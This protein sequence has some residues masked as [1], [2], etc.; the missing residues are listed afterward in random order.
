MLAGMGGRTTVFGSDRRVLLWRLRPEER[1]GE[2]VAAGTSVYSAWLAYPDAEA[3]RRE[4]GHDSDALL[5]S[6]AGRGYLIRHDGI[7]VQQILAG[8][9][10]LLRA[11]YRN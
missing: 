9:E 1:T 7:T 2:G 3:L 10:D 5:V 8:T 6:R 11:V 4:P